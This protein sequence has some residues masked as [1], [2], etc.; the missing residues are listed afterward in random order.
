VLIDPGSSQAQSCTF[1]SSDPAGTSYDFTLLGYP[2]STLTLNVADYHRARIHFTCPDVQIGP[3]YLT[4]H[5]EL[6]NSNPSGTVTP[7]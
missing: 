6:V 3:T 7:Q 5:C 2:A 4:L 1:T